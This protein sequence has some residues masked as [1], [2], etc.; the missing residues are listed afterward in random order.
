MNKKHLND[1][2]EEEINYLKE[3]YLSKTDRQLSEIL[4]RHPASSIKDKRHALSL[5]KDRA[6]RKYSF[7]DVI[8]EFAK[9]N[10]IL[11][12]DESDYKDA[13]TNSL[14]YLCPEH[15][16]KGEQSISLGHFLNGK[17]CY[18]CGRKITEDAHRIPIN[19]LDKDCKELCES[20][21]FIYKGHCYND[22]KRLCIK[23]ICPKHQEAGIQT[24]QKGNMKRDN[25]VGC[26]YCFDTKKFVFSKGEKAIEN[27]LQNKSINY[28]K[29]YIF[30]DCIDERYLPFDFYL[31][32]YIMCIEYDGQHHYKPTRFNGVSEEQAIINHLSTVRHD[33]MKNDY[34]INHDIDLLRIPYYEF[35]RINEI[36]DENILKK[37]S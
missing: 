11:L 24:M 37:I 19:V 8:Y 33:K 12:S 17:G 16:D 36:L 15:V 3:N 31:P 2:T 25:I 13:A 30:L 34:C 9:T 18:Y 4:I 1:W 28:L 6:H 7:Q 10:Y 14:R 35:N 5:N 22:Q 32:D 29:Q 21:G 20:K 23:Y 26:P 27:Y